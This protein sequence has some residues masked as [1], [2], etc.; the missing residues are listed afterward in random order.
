M[1][2]RVPDERSGGFAKIA[3]KKAAGNAIRPCDTH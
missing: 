2:E 3:L 1:L